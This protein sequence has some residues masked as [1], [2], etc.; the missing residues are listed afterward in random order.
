ML[1]VVVDHQQ[2][3][4]RCLLMYCLGS[5]RRTGF[6]S[7]HGS[8]TRETTGANDN[9]PAGPARE[10]SGAP[11]PTGQG[12]E[13]TH[14]EGAAEGH[15]GISHHDCRTVAQLM[16]M[17]NRERRISARDVHRQPA[18]CVRTAPGR[19]QATAQPP[20]PDRLRG[21]GELPHSCRCR[22]NG[23]TRHR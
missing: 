18:L 3:G 16:A 10:R 11:A 17:R 12:L 23:G 22:A 4:M 6:T 8:R 19:H 20:E 21:A 1:I 9:E 13:D 14:Q 5:P 7:E 2:H 15:G